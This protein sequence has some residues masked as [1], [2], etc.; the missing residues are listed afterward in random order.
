MIANGVNGWQESAAQ[1]KMGGRAALVKG[2]QRQGR[3]EPLRIM[4]SGSLRKCYG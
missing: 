4:P 3:W 2:G 1:V